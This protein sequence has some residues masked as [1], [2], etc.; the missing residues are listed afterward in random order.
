V[1]SAKKTRPAIPEKKMSWAD[2]KAAQQQQQQ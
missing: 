2:F 1:K